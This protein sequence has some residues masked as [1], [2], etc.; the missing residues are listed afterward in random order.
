MPFTHAAP[1]VILVIA[2]TAAGTSAS[3]QE[4][5]FAVYGRVATS[6]GSRV[7][8]DVT[9]LAMP[10][11]GGTSFGQPVEPD[12]TFQLEDL[13]RGRYV[14]FARPAFDPARQD[15]DGD[16]GGFAIVTV[17]AQNVGPVVV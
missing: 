7:R 13:T 5:S 6:D 9:V 8:A 12:G 14:I 11:D 16:E 4:R 17:A 15:A 2:L 1:S 10:V 3:P